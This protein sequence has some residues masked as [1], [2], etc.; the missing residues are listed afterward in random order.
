MGA[1]RRALLLAAMVISA[2]GVILPGTAQAS[3][4][5]SLSVSPDQVRDGASSTGTVTTGFADVGPTTVLLFSGAPSAAAVP[6]TGVVP[7]G[8]S[9]ATFTITTNAAAP[10]TF[11]TITA[12][13][14]NVPRTATLVVNQATPA[15]PPLPSSATFTIT[16]NAA[17]P[18]TFVTIT[19]AIANVPRTATLVV[20]QATPAGPSLTSVSVTPT[21]VVGGGA[22]TGTVTFTGVT[23]GANVLLSTSNPAVVQVPS[24]TVVNGGAA[25][26]A[27][28]VSTTPVTSNTT[29]TIKAAWV[30]VT[31]TTTITV[32]PGTPPAADRVTITKARW[33]SGLLIIE[34][35]STNF[36]AI[37]STYIG[38]GFA[39]ELTN[40]GGGR[41]SDQ[42]GFV[43][44]PDQL[45]V[46]SSFGGSATARVTT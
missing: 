34:A 26:A 33:K 22:A 28:P 10:E 8:S 20:N 9:S 30:G 35:T 42:R 31:R 44:R 32:T 38:G 16:T 29:V 27:F 41:Y 21:T 40:R 13:I 25:S 1:M 4:I 24:D 2:S 19:A 45:T 7:A 12:A 18:E 17:A 11:V 43:T 36:T 14:A 39:Y 37:L 5:S 3:F 46:K 23:N 6:A 15:G